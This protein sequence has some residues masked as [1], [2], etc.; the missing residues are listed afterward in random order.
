M[1][2]SFERRHRL[3]G[4]EVPEVLE[5]LRLRL[6]EHLER[7]EDK[8]QAEIAFRAYFRLSQHR[9]GRPKYPRPLTWQVMEEYVNDTSS[10]RSV[11]K[12][13]DDSVKRRLIDDVEHA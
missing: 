10:I 11:T 2:Y 5:G 4:F 1:T 6:R 8:L 9:S 13:H 3:H 7:R 12:I